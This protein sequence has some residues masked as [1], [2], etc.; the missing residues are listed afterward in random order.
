VTLERSSVVNG[1]DPGA[2]DEVVSSQESNIGLDD[3]GSRRVRHWIFDE[4]P[5]L[6][7]MTVGVLDWQTHQ[8]GTR[9]G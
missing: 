3:D 9:G 8:G 5:Y 1:V 7:P 6:A 2:E 4:I